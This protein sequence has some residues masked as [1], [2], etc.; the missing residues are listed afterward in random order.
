MKN[1]VIG[2]AWPYANG[3]LHI[4]HIAALL[5]GDVLA[6]YYRLKG[7]R[8]F[9]VSGSDCHGTPVTIR[10]RQEGRTPE[11]ISG[12]YHQEFVRVFDKLGFSYDLYTKTTDKAHKE[13][14]TEFH[15]KLYDSEFVYEKTSPEAYCEQ[16]GKVL[17]DRLVIGL[18]P[19][20]NKETRS[21]QCDNCGTVLEP[22]T[23]ID[24][25]CSECGA[26]VVFYATKQLYL[27]ISKLE[28]HLSDYL[29]SKPHWRKNAYAFTK[30]YLDEGLRDRA[31]TRS[32]DWGIDVPRLGFEDKKI[33]IWAENVLGYLSASKQVA[34]ER[35]VDF[36][37][38]WGSNA[39]HYYIHGK[40]NIP[41]HTI[42]LPALLIAH[43]DNLRLPDDIVSS[44]YLT[45]EGRKISTSQNWAV[46]LKDIVDRYNSDSLRY[47]FLANGPEK[48]DS[49][50]SWHEFAERNNSDL[51]GVYGNFVNRTLAFIVKYNNGVVPCGALEKDIEK[52]INDAYSEVGSLLED[53]QFKGALEVIFDL[54]RFGNKYYD[55]MEPWKTRHGDKEKCFNT[56][57]NCVQI[58]ANLAVLLEPILPFSSQKAIDWLGLDRAWKPQFVKEVHQLTDISILFE[59]I[60]KD[61]IEEERN[62][63]KITNT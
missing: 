6:R 43:G 58:I 25:V 61:V 32:I 56:L 60:D 47:F 28:K 29:L 9:Y 53:G 38:V 20:C 48:R 19:I 36:K 59:R 7:D 26:N 11:E 42:I 14:V 21:D 54:V 3:S 63:L 10:A 16:C 17:T 40:D 41:F 37:E 5:P 44:E 51:V 22:H 2:G 52:K 24:P 30:R 31:I 13:F 49:D 33:Y 55:T 62:R 50:F 18:C 35:G 1:I 15:R 8:V 39:R 45:L 23:V 12:F 46:W 27:A 57:Y 34:D 4:G